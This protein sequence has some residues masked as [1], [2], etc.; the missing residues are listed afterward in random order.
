MFP[1]VEEFRGIVEHWNITPAEV[2]KIQQM[3]YNFANYSPEDQAQIQSIIEDVINIANE[4]A[5]EE[6]RVL[7]DTI[8][9]HDEMVRTNSDRPVWRWVTVVAGQQWND[10]L[11]TSSYTPERWMAILGEQ[12]LRRNNIEF[13]TAYDLAVEVIGQPLNNTR[14]RAYQRANWLTVDGIIGFDTY[15][16]MLEQSV[17]TQNE[18]WSLFGTSLQEIN[19]TPAQ[20]R[21]LAIRAL[22]GENPPLNEVNTAN[23][24]T[25][26]ENHNIWVDGRIWKVTYLEMQAK[27]IRDSLVTE[28]RNNSISWDLQRDI[29]N[30]LVHANLSWANSADLLLRLEGARESLQTSNPNFDT[31]Y[32][33]FYQYVDSKREEHINDPQRQ[34]EAEVAVNRTNSSGWSFGWD[35]VQVFE[36]NMEVGELFER[37][38]W[39]AIVAGIIGFIFF[40]NRIPG[41]E[42]IPWMWSWFGRVAWLIGGAVLGG[43]EL[44]EYGIG[45]IWDGISAGNDYVRSPEARAMFDRT[46]TNVSD[47]FTETIPDI[48]WESSEEIMAWYTSF[49][50][51]FESANEE[52][53]N[54]PEFIANIVEKW[55][56][57]S[58]DTTFL[59]ASRESIQRVF[60]TGDLSWVMSASGL[61][62]LTNDLSMS[63]DEI[64]NYLRLY[65]LPR[66]NDTHA[67]F[68]DTFISSRLVNA[69]REAIAN[70]SGDFTENSRLNSIIENS[71]ADLNLVWSEAQIRAG[72]ELEILV[73][74]WN[75]SEFQI[76]NFPDLTVDEISNF[77]SLIAKLT[78]IFEIEKYI[79]D[80]IN[81]IN[82]IVIVSDR[83]TENTITQKIID[84]EALYSGFNI[85]DSRFAEMWL[86]R[87]MFSVSEYEDAYTSKRVELLEHAWRLW[88]TE[89]ALA[90]GWAIVVEDDL[91]ESRAETQREEEITN[92]EAIIESIPEEVPWV[93]S[94]PIEIR[95]Y[96]TD[97]RTSFESLQEVV[98]QND[99]AT[100]WTHEFILKSR[101]MVGLEKLDTL[102]NNYATIRARYASILGN[103]QT[104]LE[105]IPTDE[106]NEDTYASAIIELHNISEE[107]EELS[108]GVVE[109]I[110]ARAG[111]EVLRAY[112]TWA[113]SF[114]RETNAVIYMDTIF[115]PDPASEN[116]DLNILPV[117]IQTT[118]IALEWA[119]ET[120]VP[121]PDDIISNTNNL[122]AY[123]A[124]LNSRKNIIDWFEHA[125]TRDM[126]LR[127]IAEQFL[128]LQGI[129]LHAINAETNPENAWVLISSYREFVAPSISSGFWE[130][131][132]NDIRSI[133]QEQDPVEAAYNG[134]EVVLGREEYLNL[135]IDSPRFESL[136]TTDSE[137]NSISLRALYMD[138]LR[139]NDDVE[140]IWEFNAR[141]W[142]A[143]AWWTNVS[144]RAVYDK[145]EQ[146]SNDESLTE[147]L[148]VEITEI[149]EKINTTISN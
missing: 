101:A 66:F 20:A 70:I 107:F 28:L 95:N 56:V 142:R 22:L 97:H 9:I 71:L 88:V 4:P 108:W 12:S 43:W 26:Q 73:R 31:E 48:F 137:W 72:Q 131:S 143:I 79:N 58:W 127:A 128:A 17:E 60:E 125:A 147:E 77:E 13:A 129:Y 54:T 106:V 57:I 69:G 6:L 5:R 123:V 84:L 117:W 64:K 2:S 24:R 124:E 83:E 67:T 146:W 8:S 93:H 105:G 41:F 74:W 76:E 139:Q 59:N 19:I 30:L 85:D 11:N 109:G 25:Y 114:P 14:I 122:S 126:K 16:K 32:G 90:S 104:R 36:G 52:R 148:R 110:T 121:R 34:A 113:P 3:Q 111:V 102:E 149:I 145:L 96:Y 29:R 75:L 10:T 92:L 62:T 15:S 82:S 136:M 98:T 118:L 140:I 130:D 100:E 18:V 78:L 144:F 68:W 141:M 7:R 53:R 35:L 61:A 89:V 86:T 27:D 120:D 38:K 65:V 133:F 1:T 134:Q 87:E 23:I 94:S 46:T 115:A 81:L 103:L 63:V 51:W 21:E 47:F 135:N 91:S 40:G 33:E 45:R 39:T 138:F 99:T 50:S 80:E 49:V 42:N 112:I 55:S 44:L 119:F 116:I 37:N 132:W